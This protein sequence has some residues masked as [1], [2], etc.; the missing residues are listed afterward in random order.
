MHIHAKAPRAPIL[1]GGGTRK[2]QRE[3]DGAAGRQAFQQDRIDMEDLALT[4]VDELRCLP[5][6]QS[7]EVVV[8]NLPPAVGE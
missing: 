2:A 6:Y 5:A 4:V 1:I 7:V 3:I 8:T